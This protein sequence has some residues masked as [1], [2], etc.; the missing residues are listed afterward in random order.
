VKIKI[1]TKWSLRYYELQKH[2]TWFDGKCSELLDQRK[3]ANL[4][5]LEDLSE[6]IGD[7]LNNVMKPADISG[8]KRG[9]I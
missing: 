1:S 3:Q 8:I 9:N 7:N 2:K 5:W 6:I 4:Q